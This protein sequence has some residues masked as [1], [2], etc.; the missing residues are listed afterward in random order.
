MSRKSPFAPYTGLGCEPKLG[1]RSRN[2]H[3]WLGLRS[4]SRTHCAVVSPV[5]GIGERTDISNSE[6]ITILVSSTLHSYTTGGSSQKPHRTNRICISLKYPRN[7]TFFFLFNT[8]T[9][10]NEKELS[11]STRNTETFTD[12]IARLENTLYIHE[13]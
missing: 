3:S 7:C 8:R 6:K 4:K 5:T 10:F 1:P 2:P 11:T 13:I 9:S 12:T